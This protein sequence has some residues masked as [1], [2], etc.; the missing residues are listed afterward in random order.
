MAAPRRSPGS[1]IYVVNPNLTL[2]HVCMVDNL[3]ATSGVY[4]AREELL[5]AGG[6]GV[7]VSRA[8]SLLG[9]ESTVFGVSAGKVGTLVEEL[10]A[11]EGL[12]LRTTRVAGESRIVPIVVSGEPRRSLVINPPGPLLQPAEWTGFA[13][14]IVHRISA[15]RPVAVVCTGSLPRGVAPDGYNSILDAARRAGALTIVDAAGAVLRAAL[16]ARPNC[17]KVNLREVREAF[18]ANETGDSQMTEIAAAAALRAHGADT[19]IVTTGSRGAAAIAAGT[20]FTA[21]APEVLAASAT[22]AGDAF[23]GAYVA[24]AAV[25][26]SLRDAVTDAIATATASV[27]TFEPARFD[28]ARRAAL[29]G[30]V[31]VSDAPA[32]V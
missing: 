32:W 7:N 31:T 2:D 27:L 6:K 11:E 17:A 10:A 9:V 29:R 24:A 13:A 8:L 28:P 26:A 30:S 20:A 15:D 1:P 21:A 25:G 14:D 4:R 3:D 19:G 18:G 23:L 22:G 12:Q 5:A 16:A